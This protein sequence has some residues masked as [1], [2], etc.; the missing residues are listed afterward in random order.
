M[1]C[2]CVDLYRSFPCGR[3]SKNKLCNVTLSKNT[4]S[5]FNTTGKYET[6]V[7]LKLQ[8]SQFSSEGL[9]NWGRKIKTKWSSPTG[10][11]VSCVTWFIFTSCLVPLLQNMQRGHVCSSHV[12]NVRR[13]SVTCFSP[14]YVLVTK[15]WDRCHPLVYIQGHEAQR[16]QVTY[17]R[18]RHWLK[19]ASFQN[20]TSLCSWLSP[21][22]PPGRMM[23]SLH[24]EPQHVS[25][26]AVWGRAALCLFDPW[27]LG[28]AGRIRHHLCCPPVKHCPGAQAGREAKVVGWGCT[29]PRHPRHERV[30]F[31]QRL[32]FHNPWALCWGLR[33][34]DRDMEALG[35]WEPGVLRVGLFSEDEKGRQWLAEKL[36]SSFSCHAPFRRPWSSPFLFFSILVFLL[37]V[38]YLVVNVKTF[39]GRQWEKKSFVFLQPK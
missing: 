21:V 10:A 12:P 5:L 39:R 31:P 19:S 35:D 14:P 22:P 33:E 38:L 17:P 29:G 28:F 30:L 3:F 37:A 24:R 32:C 8:V 9:G 7:I 11:A 26:P 16:D 6:A 13:V 25:L 34:C 23:R 36:S 1:N 15:L 18:S 20:C 27:G 4:I 2:F